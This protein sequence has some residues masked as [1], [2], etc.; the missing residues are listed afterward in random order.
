ML[1][2]EQISCNLL[3]GAIILTRTHT[4]QFFSPEK[5]TTYLCNFLADL[6]YISIVKHYA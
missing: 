5:S 2:T 1:V 6:D 3:F 4:L